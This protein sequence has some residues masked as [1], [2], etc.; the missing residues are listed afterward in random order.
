MKKAL[1]ALLSMSI[2]GCN[3]NDGKVI[4]DFTFTTLD[5]K[6]ITQKDLKGDATIIC[7]W[8]TWCG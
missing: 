8:A 3:T 6:T 7:V 4:P 5:G 2:F 1:L